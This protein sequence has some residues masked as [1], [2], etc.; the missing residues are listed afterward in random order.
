[1]TWDA[2]GSCR[3]GTGFKVRPW[4]NIDSGTREDRYIPQQDIKHFDLCDQIV[5][6]KVENIR[7]EPLE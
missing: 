7:I 1:V 2:V 6:V 4:Q 5:A 3:N